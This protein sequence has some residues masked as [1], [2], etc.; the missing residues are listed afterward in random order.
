MTR[1]DRT[2]AVV[3]DEASVR[4]AL[5]RL[6]RLEGYAVDSFASAEGLLASLPEQVPDCAIIDV[7]LPVLSG[8]EL[9]RRIHETYP[10]VAVVFISASDDLSLA[11]VARD[12]CGARLLRKPFSSDV[13]LEA[14]AAALA[15]S[16]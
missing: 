3:D 7:H 5:G 13:L 2:I 9:E 14:V 1:P 16:S 6:L 4:A 15:S 10:D 8:F 11:R 12:A